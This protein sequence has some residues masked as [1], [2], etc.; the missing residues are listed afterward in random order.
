M[1]LTE[2]QK[3]TVDNFMGLWNRGSLDDVPSDH[4]SDILNMAFARKREVITRPGT[5]V[6]PQLPPLG[7]SVK[8]QFDACF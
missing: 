1:Y 2:Y 6:T 7:I 3:L 8:R 5:E 4:A